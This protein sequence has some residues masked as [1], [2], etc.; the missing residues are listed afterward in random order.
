MPRTLVN[1]ESPY[2]GDI[3]RNTLYARFCMRDSIVNHGESPFASHLLYTQAHILNEHIPEERALG[4]ETGLEFARATEKTV[5]Y[6]DLGITKGME[7]AIKAAEDNGIELEMRKLN[8][9][10]WELYFHETLGLKPVPPV[11]IRDEIPPEPVMPPNQIVK[12]NANTV[13]LV[14]CI[15]ITFMVLGAAFLVVYGKGW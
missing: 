2:A 5:V 12:E 14:M 15:L 1:L 7:Q 9:S 10:D 3:E 8:S 4:I 13:V 11:R 6:T